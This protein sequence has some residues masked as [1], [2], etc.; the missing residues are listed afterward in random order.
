[1]PLPEAYASLHELAAPF[2][3]AW[4]TV[5]N[6][7]GE[8]AAGLRVRSATLPVTPLATIPKEAVKTA[9]GSAASGGSIVQV[10]R[11]EYV[12]NVPVEILGKV[13]P[14]R[15]QV[16]GPFRP[17]DALIVLSSVP[18]LPG[19]LVR[20]SQSP[21]RGVEGTTPNPANQGAEAG[22]TPPSRAAAGSPTAGAAG[23]RPASPSTATK[24]SGRRPTTPAPAPTQGS[25]PPF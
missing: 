21:S 20:F 5:P 13:G 22:I 15:I 6:E 17:N 7:K 9:E 8:L 1:L 4:I 14:E 25:P 19:T 3:A 16:T 18:L 2:A 12:T 24:P 23:A 11:N 10:I